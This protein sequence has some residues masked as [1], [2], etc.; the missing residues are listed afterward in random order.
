MN[1][2]YWLL[3]KIPCLR[4]RVYVN[5]VHDSD[6]AVEGVLFAHRG[7]WL[8]LKGARLLSKNSPPVVMDGDVVIECAKV[9]FIQVV[10]S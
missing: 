1:F 8:V 2:W 5:F 9:S 7:A 4:R 3:G 10:G 6:S